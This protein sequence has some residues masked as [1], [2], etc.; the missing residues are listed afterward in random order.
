M[1][2][3]ERALGSL[4]DV[5]DPDDVALFDATDVWKAFDGIERFAANA[6]TLLAFRV[7]ETGDWKRAG[8]RSAADHLAQLGG[9]STTAARR[10]LGTSKDVRE[11][12]VL[13]DATR[14]G[15]LSPAPAEAIAPGAVADPGATD[16]LIDLART[17]NVRELRDEC[18]RTRVKA[19]PDPDATHERIRK[20]RNMRTSGDA[21]GAWR[22]SARGTADAGA[23][24]EAGLAPI[25]D[26]MFDRARAEGRNEPRET[27][28]FDALMGLVDRD[29][30]VDGKK[31]SPKARYTTLLHVDVEALVRD[32]VEGDETCEL[33]GY[34]PIP[35]RVARDLLGESISKLVITKGV[36]VMNVTHLGRGATGATDRVVVGRNRSVRTRRV[37][38]CSCRSTTATP[39]PRPITPSSRSSIR[40]CPHDHDLKTNRGW[41]LVDGRGRRKFVPPQDPRHPRNRRPP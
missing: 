27:Y 7:E 23:R 4:V 5:L 1:R 2:I 29:E 20:N 37:R 33:P 30:P 34:G 12:A 31:R 15:T 6:K 8:A 18:L 14:K 32:R 21:E 39:G 28:A 40:S 26:A 10:D 24:F 17:T 41:L 19:D 22:I 13:A 3:I 11:S 38:A 25:I 35:V 9:T 16:R 36:D